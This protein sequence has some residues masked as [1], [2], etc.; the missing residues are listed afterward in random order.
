MTN[1]RRSHQRAG[2]QLFRLL[3]A[4][5][6]SATALA[7]S[8]PAIADR[9]TSASP[10]PGAVKSLPEVHHDTSPPL[11][12]LEPSD[13]PT[14]SF[15]ALHAEDRLGPDGLPLPR[16][17]D[18]PARDVWERIEREVESSGLEEPFERLPHTQQPSAGLGQA[19]TSP[20]PS[21]TNWEGIG[22]WNANVGQTGL[23]F[24]PG[25]PQVAAGTTQVVQMVNSATSIYDKGGRLLWGPYKT[26]TLWSGFGGMCE[27]TNDGDGIVLWDTL[28]SR[29]VLSQ[30]AVSRGSGPYFE[31]VAVSQTADATGAYHRYAFQYQNFPDYPHMGVWPDGYYVSF[32]QFGPGGAGYVGPMF[33]AYDRANMLVGATATQQCTSSPIGNAGAFTSG[34]SNSYLGAQPASIDGP[35]GPRAGTPEW[36][37]GFQN[38]SSNRTALTYWKFKIDWVN[39]ANSSLLNGI[40]GS[41]LSVPGFFETCG[42]GSAA[43][44]PQN[45]GG[46]NLM[47]TLSDRLMFRL[48]YRNL[49]NAQET[50]VVSHSVASSASATGGV[51]WYELRPNYSEFTGASQSLTLHQTG[52]LGGNLSTTIATATGPGQGASGA[53]GPMGADTANWRWMPSIAMDKAGDI[54]V[55]YS[56]SSAATYPQIWYAGR[57]PGDTPGTMGAERSMF[58]CLPSGATIGACFADWA[59]SDRW[60]DYGEM[61]VDPA[62]DCTFWFTQM[63]ANNSNWTTRVGAFKYPSCGAAVNDFALSSS[64]SSVTVPQGSSTPIT[65]STSVLNGAAQSIALSTSG[66]PSGVT[67]SFGA[68]SITGGQSTTLTFAPDV[69]AQAGTSAVTVTATGPDAAHSTTI[70]LNVVQP[71]RFTPELHL[72][73]GDSPGRVLGTGFAAEPIVRA[74][75]DGRIYVT[76]PEGS[77]AGCDLWLVNPAGRI[78]TWLGAADNG[79]G[80]GDCDV[81]TSA[82]PATTPPS[83]GFDVLASGSLTFAGTGSANSP[84]TITTSGSI[85]GG[86]N[87]ASNANGSNAPS[88]DRMWLAPGA[89]SNPLEFWMSY[90]E[91]STGSLLVAKSIDG[92]IHFTQTGTPPNAI[93]SRTNN[94]TSWQGPLVVDPRNS[95][96]LYTIFLGR[97]I[98]GAANGQTDNA[99]WL[100]FSSDGAQSWNETLI[101]TDGIGRTRYG[102]IFPSLAM[103]QAGALYT[104]Y[105]DG[106]NVFLATPGPGGYIAD[107][108]N[109]VT[110]PQIDGV[111]T[112]RFPWVT[113]SK[114]GQ[115]DIVWYG[116]PDATPTASSQWGVYFARY[117]NGST[118]GAVKVNSA[119]FHTGWICDSGTGCNG[120]PGTSGDRTMLDFV[121]VSDDTNGVAHIAW[122]A[123]DSLSPVSETTHIVYA[124]ESPIDHLWISP[125]SATIPAGDSQT[126]SVH[127]RDIFDNDSGDVTGA[128]VFS[129]T[130]LGTGDSASCTGA[131]CTATSPGTHTVTASFAGK[132]VQ[133]TLEIAGSSVAS[134][135]IDPSTSTIAAGAT[136]AYTAQGADSFG[137]PLGDVTS[138]TVFEINSLRSDDQASCTGAVCT[139]TAFGEHTV[140]ATNGS[141]VATST[142]NITAGPLDHLGVS[143]ATS[144][145]PRGES[146]AYSA[147]GIDAFGNDLGDLTPTTSFAIA[148]DGTC[149]ANLC[150]G[151]IRGAHTV[152][153]TNGGKSGLAALQVIAPEAEVSATDVDFG[154]ILVGNDVV[155]A[156]TVT[157]AGDDALDI[158]PALLTGSSSFSITSDDCSGMTIAASDSCSINLRFA[159]GVVGAASGTLTIASDAPSSPDV[160]DLIG[161]GV[162]EAIGIS[163]ASLS[164]GDR[165]VGTQTASQVVTVRNQGTTAITLGVASIS[166]SAAMDFVI[167][168]DGCSSLALAGGTDCTLSLAF[169]PS[170]PGGRSATLAVPNDATVPLQVTLDG[171]GTQATLLASPLTFDFPT[172]APG[173]QSAGQTL[174]L[175]NTGT[176]PVVVGQL[177]LGGSAP[178]QFTI[179]ADGCSNQVIAV[180]ATCESTIAFAPGSSEQ[181]IAT[182]TVPN[183]ASGGPIVVRLTGT[184]APATLQASPGSVAFGDAPVGSTTTDHTV[185]VHNQGSS[186]L[187]MTG[188][189]AGGY[190]PG[191]YSVDDHCTGQVLTPSASC[192]LDIRFSPSGVGPRP[193]MFT[194]HTSAGEIGLPLSGIGRG[195]QLSS[196]PTVLS[197]TPER[198]G[199]RSAARSISISNG[200]NDALDG[201]SLVVAGPEQ[202]DFSVA[203]TSCVGRSVAAGSTCTASIAFSPSADGARTARL[204]IRTASGTLLTVPLNGIGDGVAPKSSFST[205][206]GATML[207]G[208][209][210]VQGASTDSVA[211]TLRA[212]VTFRNDVTG[213]VYPS[214]PVLGC[215]ASR[216]YCRWQIPAPGIP[217]S[218]TVNVRATDAVGNAE[219]PGP[220]ISITVL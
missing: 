186:T 11:R 212:R 70:T 177:S 185:T 138:T 24:A 217:G 19:A 3:V 67:A 48:A 119:P 197:F 53:S 131:M 93:T 216:T 180:A 124:Q 46:N 158:S 25:D 178:A 99:V 37:V 168:S 209:G 68:A 117:V 174:T 182:L 17:E 127:A 205:A 137:N 151:A 202:T 26:S 15:P 1:R 150:S 21:I 198:V 18:N 81:A 94:N 52:T 183:D 184:G 152:T 196:D 31:C 32:N 69:S 85:D 192:A 33:C 215:N 165:R 210:A 114:P 82:A 160:V 60:G 199:S 111:R 57:Q 162:S 123:N 218:Y 163:P 62:D 20:A 87:W 200:G 164:F 30:F 141:G 133:A 214:E 181:F 80:G 153:G 108:W 74:A 220:S 22:G 193:A 116:T 27:Q 54:A 171:M 128:T 207:G 66:L 135:T 140:T 115:A 142:L 132:T 34:I 91:P 98:P 129:I 106:A 84:P 58:S 6:L 76:A 120:T 102:H 88:S 179:S 14:R 170:S 63:Y 96:Y 50:M 122:T 110:V 44:V 195:P 12:S 92:G 194:I 201:A 65:L 112:V 109:Q 43:C 72:E 45:D 125:S 78:G 144:V 148:P 169:L 41:S 55:A 56:K 187:R 71:L 49:N 206:D 219:S 75:N 51:R 89:A 154:D 126:Y 166:G 203:G 134:L 36:F 7:G 107:N 155:R 9:F 42:S 28:A 208:S 59:G 161:N 204:E 5:T 139:A 79:A 16:A 97:E 29:W 113:A 95:N 47:G 143:P 39:S 156:V 146:Q 172:T 175:T 145:H 40:A 86:S 23:G 157:N 2:S 167:T 64:A 118:A 13:A 77:P 90:R 10:L 191:D 188:L 149:S 189:F 147:R 176:S 190:Y 83:G 159:P 100:G 8:T 105:S 136:Q 211:G 121:H 101:H 38:A 61:S 213:Q 130:S 173:S 103:D 35:V 4:A 104:A 73:Y